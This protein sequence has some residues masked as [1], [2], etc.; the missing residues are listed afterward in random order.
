MQA[1]NAGYKDPNNL[2]FEN[3]TV[4]GV[5]SPPKS[6]S[7]SRATTRTEEGFTKSLEKSNIHYDDVK[8]VNTDRTVFYI[9]FNFIV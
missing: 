4:L 6:V 1:T 7:V 5:T 3:I 9:L 8:K 2:K